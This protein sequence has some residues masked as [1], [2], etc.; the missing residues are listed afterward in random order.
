MECILSCFLLIQEHFKEKYFNLLNLKLCFE[1]SCYNEIQISVLIYL[2]QNITESLVM[3]IIDIVRNPSHPPAL[4]Q[5]AY[6]Y[7]YLITKVS[8]HVIHSCNNHGNFLYNFLNYGTK[9]SGFIYIDE[10]V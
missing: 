6:K 3:Q 4:K 8:C 9:F 5:E 7:L 1:L 2:K 10:R